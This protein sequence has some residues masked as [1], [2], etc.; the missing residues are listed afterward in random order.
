[1]TGT[2]AKIRSNTY[3][4]HDRTILRATAEN[5]RDQVF[6]SVHHAAVCLVKSFQGRSYFALRTQL[7]RQLRELAQELDGTF[8]CPDRDVQQED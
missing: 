5:I 4:A 3:T 7:H 6:D 1:M 2:P 8:A